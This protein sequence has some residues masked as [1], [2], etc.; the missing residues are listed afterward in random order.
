MGDEARA[1]RIEQL[2]V[3]LEK[4]MVRMSMAIESMAK[5]IAEFAEI[6]TQQQLLKQD[7][8]NKHETLVEKQAQLKASVDKLWSQVDLVKSS[9]QANTLVSSILAKIG[10]LIGGGLISYILMQAGTV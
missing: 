4:D 2:V 6:H 9:S 3:K 10:Y 1:L 5:S 7:V 8:D